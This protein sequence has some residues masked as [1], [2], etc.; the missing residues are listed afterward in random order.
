MDRTTLSRPVAVWAE[1]HEAFRDA[2]DAAFW[3]GRS[4]AGG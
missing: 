2:F 1:A 4:E 3:E